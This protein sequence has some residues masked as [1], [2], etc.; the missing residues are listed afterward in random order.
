MGPLA[1]V[2]RVVGAV[3]AVAL[4]TWTMRS[5]RFFS[6]VVRIQKDRGHTVVSSEP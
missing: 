4:I 5:N 6:S 3:L 1:A 2:A